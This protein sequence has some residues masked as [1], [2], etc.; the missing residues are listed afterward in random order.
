MTNRFLSQADC[1]DTTCG[2]SNSIEGKFICLSE[3]R[4][5]IFRFLSS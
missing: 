3:L 1:L 5:C 4:A 2:R